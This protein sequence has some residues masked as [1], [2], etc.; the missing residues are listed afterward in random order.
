[1]RTDKV[2]VTVFSDYICPFCHI[3]FHR[4]Q[5][6]QQQYDLDVEWKAFELRPETA[7]EG[8][9]LATVF[10]KKYFAMV[11][12]N[13]QQLAAEDGISFEFPTR[14][15]NSR[16]AHLIAE[17]AKD[18]GKFDEFHETAFELYWH[19]GKDIGDLDF[20]LEMA[21]SIGLD[22][23]EILAYLEREEPRDLLRRNIEELRALGTSGVPTFVIGNQ[24]INGVQPRTVF[25]RAILAVM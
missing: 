12:A 21:A 19:E 16:L 10:D 1:M 8:V 6:L 9:D 11:V 24:V 2:K 15:P 13:V 20:L 14:L 7:P 25:E 3:G 23:D 17:F 22:R 18:K 5:Q 4:M